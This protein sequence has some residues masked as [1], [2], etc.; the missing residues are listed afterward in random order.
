MAVPDFQSLML[1]LL[2]SSQD[3][4]EHSISDSIEAL[5]LQ[6]ELSDGEKKELLPSGTMPRFDNRVRWA[7]V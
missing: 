3:G 7:R 1:P 5:A 2:K 4:Q 6:L